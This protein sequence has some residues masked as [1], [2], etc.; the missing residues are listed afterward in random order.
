VKREKTIVIPDDGEPAKKPAPREPFVAWVGDDSDE[1]DV[2]KP[3]GYDANGNPLYAPRG[4]Q[5]QLR[6]R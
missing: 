2:S 1:R 3:I 5:V 6:W 4:I